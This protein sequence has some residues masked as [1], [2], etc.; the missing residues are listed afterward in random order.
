MPAGMLVSGPPTWTW[1]VVTF[2]DGK[3]NRIHGFLST[4]TAPVA[5][6]KWTGQGWVPI[7][8]SLEG[9][10]NWRMDV[11]DMGQGPRIYVT[12]DFEAMG[13][14]AAPGIVEWDGS[15]WRGLG[16]GLVISGV[17]KALIVYDVGSGP[18][19]YVLGGV[20][21]ADGIPVNGS[22]KWNGQTWSGLSADWPIAIN[23]AV[24]FDDGTGPA[25]FVGG[26]FSF[27][28]PEGIA[29]GVAKYDGTRWYRLGEG[30]NTITTAVSM[31]VYNDGRG[32]SLFVSS[33]GPVAVVGGG[34]LGTGIAQWVGCPNCY[35]DCD[36]HPASP[37]LTAHDF[38]CFMNRYAV[39]DP[40]AN[41]NVDA[42][43]DAADFVCF[44]NKFAAGCP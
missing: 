31:A 43:I 34:F 36:N 6:A 37:R 5:P 8:P 17:P 32:P 24:I 22:A 14:L 25:L 19:L 10:L 27:P 11:L 38:M 28:T 2:N 18:E 3:G 21:T 29:R 33:G 4:S 9:A 30:I 26:P 1:P 20:F 13:T 23:S 12:G 7:G 42:K 35:A 15:T 41:C 39:R 44:L 40:Y 16:S